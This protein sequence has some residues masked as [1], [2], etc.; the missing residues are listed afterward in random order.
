[1]KSA[2]ILAAAAAAITPASATLFSSTLACIVNSQRQKYD[3]TPVK[4]TTADFNELQT[5]AHQMSS[6]KK[7]I[8]GSFGNGWRK[9]PV[10]F[11]CPYAHE[12]D[13]TNEVSVVNVINNVTHSMDILN[14]KNITAVSCSAHKEVD[15]VD[16][17]T[18]KK[19]RNSHCWGMVKIYY[20]DSGNFVPAANN[21]TSTPPPTDGGYTPPGDGNQDTCYEGSTDPKCTSPGGD[22]TYTPPGGDTTYTPP[23]DDTTYTPPGDNNQD[24][25]YEGSTD[26]K[27]TSPGGDTTYTP[28]DNKDDESCDDS[29]TPG[30]GGTSPGGDTTYTPP[31]DNTTYTPPGKDDDEKC[32]IY[33][34]SDKCNPGNEDEG[35]DTYTP[36]GKDD[37][38]KC[39]IYSTSDKCNPGNDKDDTTYSNDEDDTTYSNDEDDTT[40]SND[41]DDSGDDSD[42]GSDDDQY[43]QDNGY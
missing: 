1:M 25:C 10:Q 29:T 4:T 43:N 33:S 11:T 39:D 19:T 32:D 38:E 5:E 17:K 21:C 13:G 14:A 23:G 20:T 3:L 31:G 9:I 15:Q 42:D 12:Y 28:P 36:P 24:T 26:S 7:V 35:D 41:E 6:T 40:Y 2:L 37:D 8:P 30:N 27:C 18:G 34:T 16:K 22:T